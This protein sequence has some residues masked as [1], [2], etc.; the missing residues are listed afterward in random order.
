[1]ISIKVHPSKTPN[2][3]SHQVGLYNEYLGQFTFNC[4]KH[5]AALCALAFLK[6][7]APFLKRENNDNEKGKAG[8]GKDDEKV[9]NNAVEN[10]IRSMF[11]PTDDRLAGAVD[12]VYGSMEAFVKWKRSSIS[13]PAK[14]IMGQIWADT[15]VDRAYTR[16][17]NLMAKHDRSKMLTGEGQMKSL[18]NAE[19]NK[20]RGRIKRH[21]GPSQELVTSPYLIDAN[22]INKYIKLR[23]QSVGLLKSAWASVIKKIGKVNFNGRSVNPTGSNVNQWITRHGNKGLGVFY[24]DQSRKRI[25]IVN[26]IGD[27]LGVSSESDTVRQVIRNRN[28]NIKNNPYQKEVDKSIRLWNANR[29]TV[30][31]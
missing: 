19:R 30:R 11:R 12:P 7:T 28:L 23:Q 5:E 15:N 27:T 18:H 10:D 21:G 6:F 20:Y 31:K 26:S 14:S 8:L 17:K 16:A 4:L 3:L 13:F 29:I 1:M 22:I 9:G 24:G 2:V 25:K